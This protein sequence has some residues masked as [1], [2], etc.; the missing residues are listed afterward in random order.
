M[1]ASAVIVNYNDSKNTEILAR[2][3]LSYETIDVVVVV[4]NASTDRSVDVLENIKDSKYFLFVNKN[5][6]GYG[7]GNNIGIIQSKKLFNCTHCL[8]INPDV[9]ISEETI[10]KIINT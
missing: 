2:Q 10:A 6:A 4:D 3:L 9:E 1:K 5:N 7:E 8:I